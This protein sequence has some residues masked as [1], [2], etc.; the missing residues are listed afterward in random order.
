MLLSLQFGFLNGLSF[1]MHTGGLASHG[2]DFFSTP[3]AYLNLLDGRSL[4]DTW[5]GINTYPMMTWYLSHPAFA[6]L[7][8]SWFSFLSPTPSYWAFV[9][10]SFGLMVASA[11][12]LASRCAPESWA[13]IAIWA[14]FLGS[15]PT[16]DMLVT[17]NPQSFLVLALTLIFVGIYD[18]AYAEDS[19][20]GQAML[21]GGLLLSLFCKPLALLL[22][23][24]LLAVKE[25]RRAAWTALAVYVPVS[26]LFLIVPILNPQATD[27]SD[28]L[29][30]LLHPALTE[31][32]LNIY[33]NG[34]VLN[35]AMRDNSIHWLSMMALSDYRFDHVDIYSLPV[36][37]DSLL[38][39]HT[40]EW[41]Y[42]L[43]P[44]AGVLLSCCAAFIADR[45]TRLTYALVLALALN[46]SFFLSYTIVWEYQFTAAMPVLGLLLLLRGRV[47]WE[48]TRSVLVAVTAILCLPSLYIFLIG[49]PLDRTTLALIRCD[50]VLPASAVCLTLLA[51]AGSMLWRVWKAPASAIQSPVQ[52]SVAG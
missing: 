44:A 9:A 37:L 50:R 42:K 13:R 33:K 8:G 16:F 7:I 32:A 39:A 15:V 1:D 6:V 14:A 51:V 47:A 41:L 10:L 43:V 11:H 12:L 20:R 22:L 35:P 4:F 31:Q 18:L 28:R 21:L 23:P 5:G 49:S 45:T 48:R 2:L 3:K 19:K 34:F 17:G 25:T 40:S 27:W 38:G 46:L 24:L 30:W 36:F 29:H 52:P 26:L